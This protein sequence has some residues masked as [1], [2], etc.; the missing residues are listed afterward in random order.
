MNKE[1]R[2]RYIRQSEIINGKKLQKE[3]VT[4][5]GIG[6][7]GSFTAL[8]LSKMGVGKMRSYEQDGVSLLNLPGQFYR[9]KDVGQFKSDALPEILKE[10]SGIQDIKCYN[11]F[12]KKQRLGKTVIVAVDSL[13]T[14]KKIWKEFLRQPQCKNLIEA[15]MGAELCKIYTITD[16]SRKTQKFYNDALKGKPI[17]LPCTAKTIIYNVLIAAGLISRMYKGIIQ[18]EKDLPKEAIF[19]LTMLNKLSWM[20]Q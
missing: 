6:S 13:E 5:I 12:Y 9:N 15:R 1:E 10:F 4:I 8:T 11:K 3:S 7:I 18:E 20:I 2:M 16:K 14:R 17:P 19:N